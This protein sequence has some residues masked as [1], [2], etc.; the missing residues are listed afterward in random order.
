MELENRKLILGLAKRVMELQHKLD[1][2]RGGNF[3][4]DAIQMAP[5]ASMIFGLGKQKGGNSRLAG[6][7]LLAGSELAGN[8]MIAGGFLDDIASFIGLGK[9]GGNER[10][11]GNEMIA[12]NFLDDIADGVGSA[13]NTVSNVVHTAQGVGEAAAMLGLGKK[14]RKPKATK[15][16]AQRHY[17]F[18]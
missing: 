3:I 16:T 12:G 8:E 2:M 7:E 18:N 9:Q 13:M 14:S 1:E 10:L 4:S 6:N 5:A 17:K 11:A 15:K